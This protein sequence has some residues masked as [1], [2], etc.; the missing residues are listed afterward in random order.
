M[1]NVLRKIALAVPSSMIFL[2]SLTHYFFWSSSEPPCSLHRG[3]AD[4][5]VIMSRTHVCIL[6]GTELRARSSIRHGQ[7]N[8]FN[9]TY[10]HLITEIVRGLT[11]IIMGSHKN[12]TAG[13]GLGLAFLQYNK[14]TTFLGK[15]F[16]PNAPDTVPSLR[17]SG[18]PTLDIRVT[19]RLQNT[20]SISSEGVILITH[21]EVASRITLPPPQFL[22]AALLQDLGVLVT[23]HGCA[24]T[25]WTLNINLRVEL[26]TLSP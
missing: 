19:P 18:L 15:A 11:I 2:C 10:C 7:R 25:L 17:Y 12:T 9:A 8:M 4:P 16:R 6:P 20:S 13:D 1:H 3:D 24:E 5:A 23:S 22:V 21:T 26:D 14:V